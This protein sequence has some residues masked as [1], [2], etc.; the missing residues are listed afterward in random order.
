MDP[1][2]ASTLMGAAAQAPRKVCHREQGI[3]N[4]LW[5]SSWQIKFKLQ[6]VS[7]IAINYLVFTNYQ[8]KTQIFYY[9]NM[10]NQL[11]FNT[12]ISFHV[13]KHHFLV[14]RSRNVLHRK[15]RLTLWANSRSGFWP[16]PYSVVPNCLNF[17][18]QNKLK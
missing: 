6:I 4:F 17:N 10:P 18:W 8:S 9:C 13:K 1:Q 14:W 5:S 11:V 3:R 12:I 16:W 7:R 15:R 2:L